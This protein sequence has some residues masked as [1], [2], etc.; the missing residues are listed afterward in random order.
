MLEAD[1][2]KKAMKAIERA[3]PGEVWW[4]K[5]H[6]SAYGMAGCPDILGSLQGRFFGLEFKQPGKE[7]TPIQA[8]VGAKILA[9]GGLWAVVTSAEEAVE[10]LSGLVD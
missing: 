5:Y 2:I 4:V 10:V 8:A 7:A 9:A 1:I 3:W 6:G